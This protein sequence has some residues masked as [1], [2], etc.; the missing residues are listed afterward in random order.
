MKPSL[1][2]VARSAVSK[3]CSRDLARLQKWITAERLMPTAES[4]D[5]TAVVTQL[6]RPNPLNADGGMINAH[7]E[8]LAW[9]AVDRDQDGN[10]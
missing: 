9:A 1:F 3:L 2:E 5:L 4:V 6:C 8:R 10:Q 7:A